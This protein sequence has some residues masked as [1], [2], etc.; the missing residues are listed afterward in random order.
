MP[1]FPRQWM[2]L[3]FYN[4]G[5]DLDDEGARAEAVGSSGLEYAVRRAGFHAGRAHSGRGPLHR[6]P[7]AD[8]VRAAAELPRPHAAAL[9]GA[10]FPE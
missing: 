8:R 2:E 1:V 10:V 6:H 7:G 3:G 9:L 4:F 5:I